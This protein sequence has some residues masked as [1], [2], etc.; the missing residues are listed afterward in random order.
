M[1][2]ALKESKSEEPSRMRSVG[3]VREQ[4]EFYG[5]ILADPDLRPTGLTPEARV[6]EFACNVL[7][8][9]LGEKFETK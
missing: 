9:V 4:I 7:N 2:A 5:K 3:E 1:D 6:Y 8:W